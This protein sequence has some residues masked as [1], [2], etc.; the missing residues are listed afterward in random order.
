MFEV[1]AAVGL[2]VALVFGAMFLFADTVLQQTASATAAS[3]ALLFAVTMRLGHIAK[4]LEAQKKELSQ[5]TEYLR[6][7]LETAERVIVAYADVLA[8]RSPTSA[9][10]QEPKSDGP[11]GERLGRL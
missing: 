2:V 9:P 10:P 4:H 7:M 5:Q 3:A 1:L 6:W 8:A 11:L